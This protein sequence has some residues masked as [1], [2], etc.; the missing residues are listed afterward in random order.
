[1]RA[2]IAYLRATFLVSTASSARPSLN[3]AAGNANTATVAV[4]PDVFHASHSAWQFQ[5]SSALMQESSEATKT[6]GKTCDTEEAMR[7]YSTHETWRNASAS[8][9]SQSQAIE[10]ISEQAN[11]TAQ[12]VFVNPVGGSAGQLDR[13]LSLLTPVVEATCF[14][15][16]CM[17]S[18][19]EQGKPECVTGDEFTGWCK[20]VYEEKAQIA[21]FQET[22][23]GKLR[24]LA[25]YLLERQS[26]TY[27]KIGMQ[28]DNALRKLPLCFVCETLDGRVVTLPDT[29]AAGAAGAGGNASAGA[30]T[31][32]A[33]AATATPDPN[34]A[35]NGVAGAFDQTT[36]TT[37]TTTH[38]S[39]KHKKDGDKSAA[40]HNS[41]LNLAMVL[42]PLLHHM[43]QADAILG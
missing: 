15:Y 31:A 25:A 2:I 39:G 30:A 42:W 36:T 43:L 37:T 3:A 5:S 12:T 24:S 32:N 40:I 7:T 41:G 20:D 11:I 22:G 6:R 35:A 23:Q 38:P 17:V 27:V 4:N 29:G 1:M 28:I 26:T 34:L 9:A 8:C 14:Y 16:R 21:L 19:L 10:M 13:V 18:S 33:S